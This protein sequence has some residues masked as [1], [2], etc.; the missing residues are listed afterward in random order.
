M[1]GI[2]LKLLLERAMVSSVSRQGDGS[3]GAPC[4][5]KS[6]EIRKSY[7]SE[8]EAGYKVGPRSLRTPPDLDVGDWQKFGAL[9][10]QIQL[11][12]VSYLDDL[13]PITVK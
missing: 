3:R 6:L 12:A 13:F 5:P 10:G 2:S 9:W 8:Q 11:K 7:D 1:N 4:P